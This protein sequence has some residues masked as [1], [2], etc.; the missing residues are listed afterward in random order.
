[1]SRVVL[2]VCVLCFPLAIN[3][4]KKPTVANLRSALETMRST[5]QSNRSS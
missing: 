1:M 3:A 2:V 4:Q 5:L